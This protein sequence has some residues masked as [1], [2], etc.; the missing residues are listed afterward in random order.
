M[1]GSRVLGKRVVDTG[2]EVQE[3]GVGQQVGEQVQQ[4]EGQPILTRVDYT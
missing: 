2:W 3:I 4:T 1:I